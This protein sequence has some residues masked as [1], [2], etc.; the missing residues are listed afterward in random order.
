MMMPLSPAAMALSMAVI[1][2]EVSPSVVPA[3]TVR[4][5]P[6]LDA[7]AFALFSIETKYGFEN[8]L[9][10]SAAL[11]AP[12]FVDPP[13]LPP[14]PPEPLEPHAATATAAPRAQVA[15]P[16]RRYR[17]VDMASLMRER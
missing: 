5:T 8:V 14:E 3:E 9:R 2:D 17:P 1:C 15:A 7:S 10:M 12:G 16:S 6:F 11:T 13:V 4:L